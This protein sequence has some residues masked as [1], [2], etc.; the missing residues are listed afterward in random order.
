MR[1]RRRRWRW[2]PGSIRPCGSEG[3]FNKIETPTQLPACLPFFL[4]EPLGDQSS[5]LAA[6]LAV[7]SSAG[8]KS[9]VGSLLQTFHHHRAAAE[10]GF[11][12]SSSLTALMVPTS[13][14]ANSLSLSLSFLWLIPKLPNFSCTPLI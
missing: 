13:A 9:A 8:P 1:G 11:I 10:F 2:S 14:D 7:Y 12:S 5:S 4:P 6:V 3:A